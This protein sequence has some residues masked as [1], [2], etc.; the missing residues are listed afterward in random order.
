MCEDAHAWMQYKGAHICWTRLSSRKNAGPLQKG[1][2]H[3]LDG[4]MKLWFE[5]FY[6]FKSQYIFW[7]IY[8]YIRR[9]VLIIF[10]VDRVSLSLSLSLSLAPFLTCVSDDGSVAFQFV[11]LLAWMSISFFFLNGGFLQSGTPKSFLFYFPLWTIQLL[12]YP[13]LW[14]TSKYRPSKKWLPQPRRPQWPSYLGCGEACLERANL[15]RNPS[16]EGRVYRGYLGVLDTP[17]EVPKDVASCLVD[18]GFGMTL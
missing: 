10:V 17:K 18:L 12:G 7:Y 6:S 3:Y 14:T 4:C 15:Y 2:V 5:L 9:D 16:G 8:I 11:R 1:M 13:H